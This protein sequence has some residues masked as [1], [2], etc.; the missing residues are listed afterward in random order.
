MSESRNDI[1]VDEMQSPPL[2]WSDV[3]AVVTRNAIPIVGMI[4]FDWPPLQFLVLTVFNLAL[5]IVNI[6]M[7][8]VTVATLRG[9]GRN[10]LPRMNS[11]QWIKLAMAGLFLTLLLTAI[12]AWPLFL[13]SNQD[14]GI[15][16]RGEFW[17]SALAMI[18]ASV[19]SI[20][21]E[22]ETNLR[23]SLSTEELKRRDQPRVGLAF[24][25]IGLGWILSSWSVRFGS[26]GVVILVAG[27]T[28]YSLVRELR[29]NWILGGFRKKL[30]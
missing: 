21:A 13:I 11:S 23:S 22:V 29:P 7:A 17:F 15:L 14:I 20:R 12:C 27:F 2:R 16:R 1:S 5:S 8:G 4:W 28:V 24:F 6:G 3:A 25:G 18:A 9:D 10:G 30:A 26:L 19:P